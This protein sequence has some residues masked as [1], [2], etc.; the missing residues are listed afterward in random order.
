MVSTDT[1]A[2]HSLDAKRSRLLQ[3]V[4]A[5]L[6]LHCLEC[7]YESD[8]LIGTSVAKPSVSIPCHS[9]RGLGVMDLCDQPI[10]EAAF[11]AAVQRHSYRS[12]E[13][14][15]LRQLLQV[16]MK[17]SILLRVIVASVYGR[18]THVAAVAVFSCTRSASRNGLCIA[19]SLPEA[20]VGGCRQKVAFPC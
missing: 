8:A 11:E 17:L 20:F 19:C 16:P 3:I 13:P 6:Y 14:R 1:P 7:R 5:T 12:L 10:F 2:P 4:N 9:C 15:L 18:V